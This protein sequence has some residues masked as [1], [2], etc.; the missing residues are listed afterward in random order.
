MRCRYD[1]ACNARAAAFADRWAKVSADSKKVFVS[2]RCGR[3]A[4]IRLIDRL[5]CC[6]G[7]GELAF[8]IATTDRADSRHQQSAS[9]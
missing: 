9:G 4:R 2:R 5:F 3:S 7:F 8:P 6:S 1:F